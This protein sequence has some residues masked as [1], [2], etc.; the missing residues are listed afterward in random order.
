MGKTLTEILADFACDVEFAELPPEVVEDC[1]R[2]LLDSIGCGLAGVEE[3]KG[4]IGVECARLIGGPDGDA[5]MFGTP[6]RTSAFGAAFA[7]GESINALDF[8]SV[9]PPG[10]V[11]PYVLPGALAIGEVA[12]SSGRR[13]IEAVA[14]SHEVSYRFGKSMDYLRTP[15]GGEMQLPSVLGF[16][17]TVF[18]ATLAVTMLHGYDREVTADAL[19]IAGAITPV[20]SYRTWMDNVPNSSIKYTMAGPITQA[21]LI[22]AHS[23]GLG[24]TGDRCVLDDAEFGY[25]RFIGSDRW[26]P[27]NLIRDLGRSWGFPKEHSYKP[28]PHCRVTHTPLDAL[29][30]LLDE[31]DIKPEEIDAIRCWGEG[32]VEQPV[33]LYNDVH[34]PHEAQFSIAHGLAVGAHRIPPGRAWQAPET[35]RSPSVLQL[36]TKVSFAPHPDYVSKLSQ[37]PSGRPTRV[38]IDARGQTFV[39]ER[40]HPKGSVTSDPGTYM[41]TDELVTKFRINADGVLAAGQIDEL[42]DGVLHLEEFDDVRALLRAAGKATP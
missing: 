9:L 39:A 14:V 37:D 34:H 17:S 22:A 6:Y 24:H 36:M 18:G 11:A 28:Y 1:K 30:A 26:E 4:R 10:H 42:V 29:N 32:W 40:S 19:G 3:P 21:S 2:V 7:N 16:T 15:K 23:A 5:T 31:H 35:L 33:W 20:N 27:E 41:T 25:R 38:E 8:D 13:L 12:R